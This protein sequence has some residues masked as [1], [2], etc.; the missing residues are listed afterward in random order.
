V[1]SVPRMR[2]WAVS[3]LVCFG[4]MMYLYRVGEAGSDSATRERRSG[5]VTA[6][7]P[8]DS[9]TKRKLRRENYLE[10]GVRNTPGVRF[11]LGPARHG[12]PGSLMPAPET[13]P[14]RFAAI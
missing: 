2:S 1:H 6:A 12:T 7:H 10:T 13:S 8:A 3:M 9:E 4:F 11:V 5:A 14:R